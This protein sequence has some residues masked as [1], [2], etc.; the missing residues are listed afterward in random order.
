MGAAGS[1][2]RGSRNSA[3]GRRRGL[4][5]LLL[6]FIL[7]LSAAAGDVCAARGMKSVGD[8]SAVPSKSLLNTVL[9]AVQ[10]F[11]LWLGI[12]WK[13]VAFFSFLALL[14]RA[15]LSWVV[16]A[17]A[18]SFVLETLA[19]KY[20]LNEK[21]SAARWAGAVCICVGVGLLSF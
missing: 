5:P 16:P 6:L 12:F 9:R 19:A 8:V 2:S 20:W 3:R 4:I 14:S 21:I 1:S 10:N 11:Y 7:V 17:S 18:I 15:Q 13:A